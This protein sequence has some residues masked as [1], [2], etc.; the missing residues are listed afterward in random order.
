MLTCCAD[1]VIGSR[2]RPRLICKEHL[3]RWQLPDR[4]RNM[5]LSL[6]IKGVAERWGLRNRRRS[7]TPGVHVLQML[8]LSVSATLQKLRDDFSLRDN[9]SGSASSSHPRLLPKL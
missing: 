3:E 2:H 8:F 6:W 7:P 5:A 1:D 4:L 9:I